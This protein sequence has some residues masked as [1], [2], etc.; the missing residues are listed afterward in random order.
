MKYPKLPTPKG[1]S[2]GQ[3]VSQNPSVVE[4]IDK[5]PVDEAGT[6]IRRTKRR[7]KF[8]EFCRFFGFNRD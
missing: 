6:P 5:P 2:H 8:L 4:K 1:G 3:R 7:V